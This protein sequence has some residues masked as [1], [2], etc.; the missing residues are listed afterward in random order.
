MN[1]PQIICGMHVDRR[2]GNAFTLPF[3]NAEANSKWKL[4]AKGVPPTLRVQ[5]PR[6]LS[7]QLN[8]NLSRFPESRPHL[9]E[10]NSGLDWLRTSQLNATT[11][12]R[13]ISVAA[14]RRGGATPKVFHGSVP[15][16]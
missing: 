15:M 9:E 4:P 11:A 6:P 5:N 14:T 16:V 7:P 13:S 8:R 3:S 1:I 10:R 12:V 2:S